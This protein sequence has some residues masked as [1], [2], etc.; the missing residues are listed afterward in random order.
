[1][2]SHGGATPAGAADEPTRAGGDV[3]AALDLPRDATVRYFG[4]YAIQEEMGRGGMG[5]VYRAIQVS[6]N[7]PVAL[8]MI[9]AGDPGRR[10]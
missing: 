4:D 3:P 10:R 1:M 5:I 9:K 8:K 2:I 6:L 7:R